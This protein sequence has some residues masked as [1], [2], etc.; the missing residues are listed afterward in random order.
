MEQ[1]APK[2]AENF[3]KAMENTES[4]LDKNRRLSVLEAF[5]YGTKRTT[6]GFEQAGK[7]VTEHALIDDNGD[8]VGHPAAEAGDGGLAR[9]TYLDSLP[10]QQA[11]GDVTLAGLFEERMRMEGAIEQLKARKGQMKTEEYEPALEKML[12][13]LA[14][15]GRSIRMR[16]KR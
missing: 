1:N 12:I 11:G 4:D 13:D 16:Q 6:S 9:V 3:I 2:F 7:L 14:R 10:L 5:E 8:G 15:L